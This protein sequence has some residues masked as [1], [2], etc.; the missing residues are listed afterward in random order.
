MMPGSRARVIGEVLGVADGDE[1]GLRTATALLTVIYDILQ[2]FIFFL[3]F[4]HKLLDS[5][6]FGHK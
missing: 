3:H 5:A 1:F 6:E 2:Y 4:V